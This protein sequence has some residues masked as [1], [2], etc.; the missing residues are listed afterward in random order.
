MNANQALKLTQENWSENEDKYLSYIVGYQQK[1]E[2]AAK[3]GKAA[4]SV[5]IL[6]TNN[7]G[8]L[9]FISTFFEQQGFFVGFQNIS[10]GEVSIYLN[11][12]NEPIGSRAYKTANEFLNSIK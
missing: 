9:D 2:Q 7:F 4:C 5:A 11:W 10:S 3:E 12:K 8:L 6:P 1:I